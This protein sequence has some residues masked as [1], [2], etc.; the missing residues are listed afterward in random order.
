MLK[1]CGRVAMD[2]AFVG[3]WISVRAANGVPKSNK[4]WAAAVREIMAH[5]DDVR[6]QA[7]VG[8][9]G[10]IDGLDVNRLAVLRAGFEH[11][12]A[13][14]VLAQKLYLVLTV[15]SDGHSFGESDAAVLV[16]TMRK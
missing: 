6:G 14:N 2:V 16:W 12:G 11:L 1:I 7:Q 13:E 9:A 3:S 15:F 5:T 4:A 8:I 10:E